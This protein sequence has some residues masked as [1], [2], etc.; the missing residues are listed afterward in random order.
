MLRILYKCNNPEASIKCL[1]E[2]E[3]EKEELTT[4]LLS[5][6]DELPNRGL[7]SFMINE[8]SKYFGVWRHLF[9]GKHDISRLVLEKEVMWSTLETL[10]AVIQH[11]VESEAALS[12]NVFAIGSHGA[13]EGFPPYI[14]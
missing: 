13:E 5:A 9:K 11:S 12:I 2:L 7:F 14:Q 6:Y 1:T 10:P 4:K 3:K 8:E